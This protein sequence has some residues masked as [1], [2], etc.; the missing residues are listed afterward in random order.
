VSL[1]AGTSTREPRLV[2]GDQRMTAAYSSPG[3]R[4]QRDGWSGPMTPALGLFSRSICELEAGAPIRTQQASARCV[5]ITGTVPG[6]EP[7]A[8]TKKTSGS[9]GTGR[10]RKLL[11]CHLRPA[12]SAMSGWC[13]WRIH[14]K[15]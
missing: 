1:G 2:I 8:T 13:A 10:I 12:L 7:S 6:S 9:S 4:D 5:G 14:P 15:P 3:V 11:A